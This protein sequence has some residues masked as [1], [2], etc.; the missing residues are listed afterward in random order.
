MLIIPNSHDL[1][2]VAV[3][4][5]TRME[6]CNRHILVKKWQ[7]KLILDNRSCQYAVRAISSKKTSKISRFKK[8]KNRS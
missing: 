6:S 3:R 5:C 8:V 7:R 1:N 4:I 2:D